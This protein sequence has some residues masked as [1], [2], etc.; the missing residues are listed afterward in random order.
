LKC[1]VIFTA[2]KRFETLNDLVED[3]LISMYIEMNAKDYIETMDF[4]VDPPPEPP[5]RSESTR[6]RISSSDRNETP[7]VNTQACIPFTSN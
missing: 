5:K 3:G 1:H 4:M 6:T 7:T 2:E